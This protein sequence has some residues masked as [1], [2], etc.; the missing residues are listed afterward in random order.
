MRIIFIYIAL[1]CYH[2]GSIWRSLGTHMRHHDV[3]VI[4]VSVLVVR[5]H[6]I[7]TLLYFIKDNMRQVCSVSPKDSGCHTTSICVLR[8]WARASLTYLVIALRTLNY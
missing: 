2:S 7:I 5:H 3:F 8:A 4:V 1:V 6:A